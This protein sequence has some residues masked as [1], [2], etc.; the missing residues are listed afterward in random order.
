[1]RRIDIE[2]WQRRDHFNLY[3]DW[4]YPHFSLTANVDLTAY[5][6]YI[7]QHGISVNVAII[8]VLART[9][10]E[11]PEFRQRIRGNDVVE[12][13]LVH[14]SSTI[15]TDDDLFSYCTFDF[16]PDFSVFAPRAVD[17]ITYVRE[18]R[19][20]EDELGRDDYLFMTAIPWVSFTHMMHP[21]DLKSVDSV[22]RIAW[23][24]FFEDGERLKMPLGIQG[25]HSLMDGIHLGRYY[26][27]V[28]DYLNQPEYLLK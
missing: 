24:K 18:N 11:I 27:K 3:K 8:Y 5:Y 12:H 20:L 16:D 10:N 2:S 22:P 9:A 7:K 25:H 26:E 17:T 14:P 15:L 19:I 23:G 1:M 28:Q 21:I 13:D 6:P 4:T